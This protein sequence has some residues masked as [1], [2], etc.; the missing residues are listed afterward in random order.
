L[1]LHG[2]FCV[3]ALVLGSGAARADRLIWIPTGY[4]S[5]LQGEYMAEADGKR[6]VLTGQ[7][8]IGKQFE[9]LAR[10]Y[11]DFEDK[12]R[13]EFGGQVQ[14]LREGFATPAVAVGV[15]DVTDEGPRG[16]RFFGVV[17]KT[18]PIVNKLPLGIRDV[19][20]HAGVGSNRL[21][22]LFLGGQVG[23][24]FGFRLYAEHDTRN[25]NAGISWD[26]ISLIRVKAES[27]DGDIFLGAQLISPL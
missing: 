5:G 1:K 15:W 20:V 24:P 7:F 26:P 19:R 9:L 21:S 8:G 17:S 27:W 12:D 6:G 23:F 16:R 11:K 18:V 14:V 2:L 3:M 13:T 10:H 25:F 4:T 22:G